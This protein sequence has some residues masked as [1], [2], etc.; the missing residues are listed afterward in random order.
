MLNSLATRS[1]KCTRQRLSR[2]NPLG[3]SLSDLLGGLPAPPRDC[4]PASL[5][6][7]GSHGFSRLRANFIRTRAVRQ[8]KSG[9]SHFTIVPGWTMVN[10]AWIVVIIRISQATR[11]TLKVPVGAGFSSLPMMAG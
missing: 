8:A 4:R 6:L 7:S 5:F 10:P 3:P 11:L 9:S 2:L 1:A